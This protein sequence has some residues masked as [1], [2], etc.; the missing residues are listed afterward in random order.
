VKSAQSVVQ[1]FFTRIL[2][3]FAL[4]ASQIQ[5]AE[6]QLRT[7]VILIMADDLSYGDLSCYGSKKHRT[8]VLDKLA[9]EGMRLT[10][11]Y[12]GATICTP[13]RMALLTGCYPSRLGWQGGVMGHKISPQTGLPPSVPTIAEIFRDK[14]YR[15]ALS[16]KWHLGEAP[17]SLPNDRGFEE[18]YYIRSSNNQ[19]KILWQN[20][21]IVADPFDNRLLT[22]LF[23]EAAIKFLRTPGDKPFFLYLPFTAPHFPAE[24]HPDWKEK[25]NNAAYGDVVEEL[26]ARIGEILIAL[27]ET[28]QEK[29]TMLVFLS[30]NGPEG[31][32][33]P[34]NSAEPHRGG[35]WTTLE[36]G[37]RVPCI[38]SWPGIIAA[39][40]VK[41]NIVSAIDLLPTIAHACGIS[42]EQKN[43]GTPID[44]INLWSTLQNLSADA[45]QR[46]TLLYW[47]GWAT[48]QAIRQ[49]QWKLYFDEVTDIPDTKIGPALF[50]LSNDPREEKNLAKQ[51]PE[52]VADMLKQART[53]LNAIAEK[54]LTMAGAADNESPNKIKSPRWLP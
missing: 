35:K 17:G 36:G 49:D 26:D 14:G 1:H 39:G 40:Q 27:K 9:A 7:N 47:E 52:R 23:T 31:N 33:R 20:D 12:S 19:T 53:E 22:K 24:A 29:N 28:N 45:P 50:D 37:S 54:S 42:L 30:D 16:G 10:N 34:F 51:Q 6:P 15:T 3:L 5:A 8:P 41:D 46:H 2:V 13:S 4:I 21:K 38:V 48:P 44:G 25:S 18:T 32:Q 11:F 43:D